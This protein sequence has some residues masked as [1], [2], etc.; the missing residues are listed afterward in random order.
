MAATL[1]KKTAT[2]CAGVTANGTADCYAVVD[3]LKT[4]GY[5]GVPYG[6]SSAATSANFKDGKNR[7]VILPHNRS[8]QGCVLPQ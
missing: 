5:T 7:A 6:N 4:K 2:I 3:R 8:L 1:G